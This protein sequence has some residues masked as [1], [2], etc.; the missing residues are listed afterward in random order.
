MRP[1]YRLYK[2]RSTRSLRPRFCTLQ[3]KTGSNSGIFRLGITAPSGI[4]PSRCPSVHEAGNTNSRLALTGVQADSQAA[5]HVEGQVVVAG[6]LEVRSSATFGCTHHYHG[7]QYG[8]VGWMNHNPDNK[9]AR[10]S[11]KE[12]E[13]LRQIRTVSESA[14][15]NTVRPPPRRAR[16][17]RN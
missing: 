11:N 3:K 7:S 8:R 2:R 10:L 12:N 15:S 1:Y 13:F 4:P 14:A 16:A 17:K 6:D 9:V 5:S